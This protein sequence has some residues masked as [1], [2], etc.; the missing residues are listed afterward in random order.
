M[1]G[2]LIVKKWLSPEGIEV[3]GFEQILASF[4]KKKDIFFLYGWNYDEIVLLV[5]KFYFIFLL[6]L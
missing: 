2:F 5:L 6:K 4:S 3:S 1:V